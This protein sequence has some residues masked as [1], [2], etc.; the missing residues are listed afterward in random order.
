M[1]PAVVTFLT[2]LLVLCVRGQ[3]D[4]RSESCKCSNGFIGRIIPKHI[5]AGPFIH[6]PSVFCSRTEITL[7]TTANMEK[8]VNPQSPLGKLILNNNQKKKAAVSATTTSGQ[9]NTVSSSS[10]KT[11]SKL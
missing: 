9:T 2:C 10:L 11:T 7:I 8:C 5:R 4:N 1:N 6:E 3:S